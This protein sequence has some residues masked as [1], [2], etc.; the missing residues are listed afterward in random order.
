[1]S[2]DIN[3]TANQADSMNEN[4]QSM[5]VALNTVAENVTRSSTESAQIATNTANIETNRTNILITDI[6]NK[7][8]MET[9]F[10]IDTTYSKLYKQGQHV[11]GTLVLKKSTGVYNSTGDNIAVIVDYPPTSTIISAA[12]LTNT[13]NHMQNIGWVYISSSSETPSGLIIIRDDVGTIN[14]CAIIQVDYVT[15]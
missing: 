7:V 15:T 13:V 14:N 11:F 2:T 4:L 3:F 5:I 6:T 1:M 10:T 12:G 8:T 9:G